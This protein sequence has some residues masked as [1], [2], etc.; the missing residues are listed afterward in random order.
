MV[1]K[2]GSATA[3]LATVLLFVAPSLAQTEYPKG[4]C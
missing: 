3:S 1:L 4:I 2:A